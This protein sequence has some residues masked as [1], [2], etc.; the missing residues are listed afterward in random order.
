M[1][2]PSRYIRCLKRGWAIPA[3]AALDMCKEVEK[4]VWRSMTPL[5]QFRGVPANVTRKEEGKQFEAILRFGTSRNRRTQAASFAG[6]PDFVRDEKIHGSAETFYDRGRRATPN[7]R[8]PST[9]PLSPE[10]VPPNYFI[11]LISDRWL[12]AETISFKHLILSEKYPP[13]TPLDLQPLPLSALHNKES[14]AICSNTIQSFNKI[15]TQVF[16]ALYT[17][18]ENV[19]IGAPTGS[20]KTI[21]AEFGYGASTSSYEWFVL[22]HTRKWST[23]A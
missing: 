8:T 18:D 12:H 7:S 17:T 13:P 4:R 14:E 19:F 22:S 5:R 1:A 10:P 3:R 16:Q 6:S 2:D 23:S 11:C 9:A 20:G 15:Q 21:C